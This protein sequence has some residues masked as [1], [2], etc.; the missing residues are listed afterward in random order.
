MNDDELLER[1]RRSNDADLLEE[2]VRRNVGPVYRFVA[3]MI[4]SGDAVDDLVQDVLLNVVRNIDRFRGESSFSTWVYRI[5]LNRVRRFWKT[6]KKNLP[7]VDVKTAEAIADQVRHSSEA[8]ELKS[9]IGAAIEELSPALRAAMLLTVV[10]GLSPEEAAK[11]EGCNVANIHW[12]IHK[13][14]KILK[15][16]LQRYI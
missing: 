13:A 12:R 1:F 15:D 11:V 3:S 4:G 8:N 9:L 10:E 14:R 5:A 2:L 16:R 6:S 7:T